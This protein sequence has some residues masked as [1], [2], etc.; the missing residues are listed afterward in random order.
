MPQ[1]GDFKTRVDTMENH[2]QFRVGGDG[3]VQKNDSNVLGRLLRW[4]GDKTGLTGEGNKATMDAFKD[5]LK[6][7][8]GPGAGE[9][10]FNEVLGQRYQD[11]RPLSARKVTETMQRAI[12]LQAETQRAGRAQGPVFQTVAAT[13]RIDGNVSTRNVG[14]TH[15]VHFFNVTLPELDQAIQQQRND[16][17]GMSHLQARMN[18]LKGAL[19]EAYGNREVGKQSVFTAPE[20]LFKG[21]EGANLSESEMKSVVRELTRMSGDYPGM[22][23]FPGTILWTRPNPTVFDGPNQHQ[24]D[25]VFN[26]APVV[27]DGQLVHMNYKMNDGGDIVIAGRLEPNREQIFVNSNDD[28][29][30]ECV[31]QAKEDLKPGGSLREWEK[32]L[33]PNGEVGPNNHHFE[34][35]GVRYG[36]DVCADHG[37]AKGER[38]QKG[39]GESQFFVLLSAGSKLM[40]NNIPGG[41]GTVAVSV[42][43][44]TGYAMSGTVGGDGTTLN[45][46]PTISHPQTQVLEDFLDVARNGIAQPPRILQALDRAIANLQGNPHDL[47]SQQLLEVVQTLKASID[48]DPAITRENVIAGIR[49]RRVGGDPQAPVS[50]RDILE[51]GQRALKTRLNQALPGLSGKEP[52]PLPCEQVP[53]SVVRGVLTNFLDPI[54]RAQLA[55]PQQ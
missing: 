52:A 40:G 25:L 8:F 17:H 28:K 26:T 53:I 13:V 12:A 19:D 3:V 42:D 44:I 50:E 11:G 47:W 30:S 22:L 41:P 34:V 29:Y 16:H 14:N 7:A 9:Q 23:I 43:S 15:R 39:L 10:A 21:V 38:E 4:I 6:T 24:S 49:E 46:Q 27:K 37:Q 33:T 48:V 18:L 45:Q 31:N 2:R 54:L 5:S 1:I 35:G 20:W 36:L 32:E 55:P 51:E